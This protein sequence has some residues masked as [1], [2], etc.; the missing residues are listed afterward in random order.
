MIT[1]SKNL[2]FLFQCMAHCWYLAVDMQLYLLSPILVWP[3]WKYGQKF[4]PVL[5]ALLWLWLITLFSYFVSGKYRMSFFANDDRLLRT[6][7]ETHTRYG[8]WLIGL[9]LAYLLYYQKGKQV[10]LHWSVVV[11]GWVVSLGM[12][13]AVIFGMQPLAQIAYKQHSQWVRYVQHTCMVTGL[14]MGYLGMYKWIRR[15]H[16]QFL[17]LEILATSGKIDVFD[18]FTSFSSSIFNAFCLQSALKFFKCKHCLQ[19]LGRYWIYIDCSCNMDIS[20]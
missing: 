4:L 11:F 10:K 19:G 20:F 14:V 16:Q 5:I 9:F 17:E 15:L 3:V 12:F 18:V 2:T 7:T 8:P 6:Y 13:M 1:V